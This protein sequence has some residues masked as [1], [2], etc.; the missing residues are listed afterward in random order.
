MQET[1]KSWIRRGVVLALVAG[2]VVAA[3]LAFRPTPGVV[4][5]VE[6]TS[7]PMTV[8]IDEDG[9]TRVR[10]RYLVS[11]PVGGNLARV[12]L[13]PGD[14]VKAG[15]TLAR[16]E[17]IAPPLVD[18]QARAEVIARLRAAEAAQRQAKAAIG[19]AEVT[20]SFASE[21][22]KRQRGLL[23]SGSSSQR[24]VDLAEVQFEGASK[25][26]ESAQFGAKV[27]GYEAE[28]A[29]AA[30]RRIDGA[31]SPGTGKAARVEGE[32]SEE[33]LMQIVSPVDGRVLLIHNQSGG[34]VA[35]GAPIMEIAD[36]ANLEV[37][38][39]VLTSDAT[40]IRPGARV[41]VTRWGG[42]KAL[43]GRVRLV[44]P[45]AFTK[46]SA[47]GVEEQ[48]VNVIVDLVDPPEDWKSLGDGY[49]VEVAIV[50]WDSPDTLQVPVSAL[51]RKG[52]EWAVYVEESGV[53]RLRVVQVGRRQGIAAEILAGLTKGERVIPHPSDSLSDGA[54]VQPR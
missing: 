36:P 52:E 51:V 12:E 6:V 8:T 21:E 43:S 31:T 11:A 54:A 19:R 7:A 15:D 22:L 42:E 48:R 18:A 1:R 16:L 23:S 29:R 10:D 44:E 32:A 24:E 46:V 37:V 39:D 17:A 20:K 14:D 41:S 53:A 2:G 25:E 27:A 5:V 28:V 13:H 38:V 47:L 33:D 35:P 4:D 50:I 45:S 40:V 49:R 9:R 34:V 3:A 30:L 26:V